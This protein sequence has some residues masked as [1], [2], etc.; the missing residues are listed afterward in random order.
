MSKR[1]LTIVGLLLIGLVIPAFAAPAQPRLARPR[2]VSAMRVGGPRLRRPF[3]RRPVVIAPR[4][5]ERPL[6]VPGPAYAQPL[7]VAPAVSAPRKTSQIGLSGGYIGG[8]PAVAGEVRWL[9][10]W[11]LSSTS[12]RLGAAYAVGADPNGVTRKH[13]LVMVDGI[14]H[15]NPVN[16]PGVNPYLGAGVNYDAYTT[17][18]VNGSIGGEIYLGMEAGTI[19]SGQ[20]FLEAGYGK[21]RTG[22][23]PSTS[24]LFVM[25]GFR[26]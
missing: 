22:F 5:I 17:G 3:V 19:D 1:N 16:T 14:Y 23:S 6:V 15:L 4:V 11:G 9:E 26:F 13:A 12:L 20:I 21:I 25:T 7:P 10:P 2:K 8:I 24:G 18:R